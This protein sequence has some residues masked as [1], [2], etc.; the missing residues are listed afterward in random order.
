MVLHAYKPMFSPARDLALA[1]HDVA[2]LL[3]TYSDQRARELGTT[4]AQWAVLARLQRCEGVKQNELAEALDL[5][6]IT[7]GR[8]IDKLTAAGLVERRDDPADRRAHRLYLTDRAEPALR[9]LALLAEDVMG[10]AL[11]GLD[12]K[13]IRALR[14]G[15]IAIKANLKNELNSGASV[16]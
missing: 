12:E 9:E 10:R 3:R 15:L 14:D 1:L 4:R 7:L 2:R 16:K 13:E 6:P 8:L 5:A 11:A